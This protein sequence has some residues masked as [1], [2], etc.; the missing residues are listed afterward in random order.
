MPINKL[1]PKYKTVRGRSRGRRPRKTKRR[2][3]NRSKSRP[4]KTKRRPKRRSRSMLFSMRGGGKCPICR[5]GEGETTLEPWAPNK[6]GAIVGRR[7]ADD[8][9]GPVTKES[10][11]RWCPVCFVVKGP[12]DMVMLPCK[13]ILCRVCADKVGFRP[14]GHKDLQIVAGWEPALAAAI[15][16]GYDPAAEQAAWDALP[17]ERRPGLT[18]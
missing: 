1:E 5:A 10:S 18:V 9:V 3:T 14:E 17:P 8:P 15:A 13:H 6:E 7:S 2:P 16:A 4:R 11:D 12:D